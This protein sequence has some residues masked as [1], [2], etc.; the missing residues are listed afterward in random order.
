[1]SNTRGSWTLYAGF[2]GVTN[3]SMFLGASEIQIFLFCFVLF[4]LAFI[5]YNVMKY[6]KILIKCNAYILQP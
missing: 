5:I 4:L 6:R 1:M 3:I 2:C